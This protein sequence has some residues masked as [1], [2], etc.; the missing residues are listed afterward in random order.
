MVLI[1]REK[2]LEAFHNKL[3]DYRTNLEFI[4]KLV[5]N[6]RLKEADKALFELKPLFGELHRSVHDLGRFV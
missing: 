4:E 5:Q 1:M 6:N 3:K 2:K